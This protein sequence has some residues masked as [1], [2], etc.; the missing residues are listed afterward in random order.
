MWNNLKICFQIFFFIILLFFKIGF[1]TAKLSNNYNFLIMALI[2]SLYHIYFKDD[3]GENFTTISSKNRTC[4][5][6]VFLI[7]DFRVVDCINS[8][9]WRWSFGGKFKILSIKLSQ[10]M[11]A[12]SRCS[13][14]AIYRFQAI[15]EKTHVGRALA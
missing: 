3:V 4:T 13:K 9:I 14:N 11:A 10:N 7:A 15:F 1:L 5:E 6:C 2:S 12:C 8:G